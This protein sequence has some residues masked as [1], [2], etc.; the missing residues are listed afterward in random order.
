LREPLFHERASRA[1]RT[2]CSSVPSAPARRISRSRSVSKLR[3]SVAE[4]HFQ[5]AADLMC[6]LIE[7]RDEKELGRFHC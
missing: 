3:D 4:F 5:R 2:Y 7:A 6:A 1:A